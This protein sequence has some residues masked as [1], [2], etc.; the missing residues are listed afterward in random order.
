ML[1]ELI[2]KAYFL[3]KAL[4][5]FREPVKCIVKLVWT[6]HVRVTK[7][8]IVWGDDMKTV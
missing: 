3:Q 2:R 7:A 5:D 1:S 8:R 4:H 6:R